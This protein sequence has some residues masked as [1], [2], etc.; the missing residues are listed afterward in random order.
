M[1]ENGPIMLYSNALNCVDYADKNIV[2]VCLFIL[3]EH[4]VAYQISYMS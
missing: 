4:V 3:H 2:L 1:L